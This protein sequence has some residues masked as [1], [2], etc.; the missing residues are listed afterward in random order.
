MLGDVLSGRDA[1]RASGD[2]RVE[3]RRAARGRVLHRERHHR[4]EVAPLAAYD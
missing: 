1:G 4:A 3:H 2:P